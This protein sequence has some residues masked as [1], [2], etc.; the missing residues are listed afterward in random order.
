MALGKKLFLLFPI[1][2]ESDSWGGKKNK[3][4]EKKGGAASW[5]C[6]K[7]RKSAQ[8][9]EALAPWKTSKRKGGTI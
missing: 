7:Q 5:A 6:G 2:G 4:T 1:L 8:S 9:P 3:K